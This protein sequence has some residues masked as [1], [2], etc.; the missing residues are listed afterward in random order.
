MFCIPIIARDTEEALEKIDRTAPFADM[1]EIRLDMMDSFDLH[2]IIQASRKPTLVTY[3]SENEGGR[4]SA[5]PKSQTDYLL[6]AIHE[7]AD[8][9]DVELSLPREWRDKI[10]NA[11]KGSD[12]VISTHRDSGTPLQDDLEKILRD[13]IDTGAHIV[14]IVTRAET[15]EDN[16]R[17]LQLIPMAHT[18]GVEIIAFCMGPMGRISRIFAH[19]MGSYLTFA[20]LEE[21]EESAPG[22]ISIHEMKKI[23]EMLSF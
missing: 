18:L 4:G 3:R 20:S 17:M 8:L 5:D 6:T 21:G 22:Q 16:L 10:F 11:N 23:L 7:G 12:I 13:S 19:L 2:Q 15:H 14:K 1:L 9:V